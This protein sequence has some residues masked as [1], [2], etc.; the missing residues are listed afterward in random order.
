ML[1]V[2][3]VVETPSSQSIRARQVSS[4]FD[5][6][7]R[8]KTRLEWHVE[9]DLDAPWNVGLVVGPSGSGKSSIMRRI[10]GEPAQNDWSAASVLDDF[11]ANLSVEQ[12]SG[13]CQ[14]VGF[15]TI[16]A[17]LR[18][19]AVLSNGEKFRVDLARR[20]LEQDDPV[21]VDE[22]TSVVDR[23]VAQIGSNAVQKWVRRN[24]RQFV[25][26]TCHYDVIEWLQPDWVLD[27]ATCQFQRRRLQ[28]R[29]AVDVVVGRVP[30]AAWALFSPFHYLT[31]ELP[32]Q[33]TCFG[34]WASGRLAAFL[35]VRTVPVSCGAER[36][37]AIRMVSRVVTLPDWQGLGLAMI[38]QDAIAAQ[39][40]GA[41]YRFRCPPA[42]PS[43]VR[44]FDRSPNWRLVKKPGSFDTRL[45]GSTEA[46]RRRGVGRG[47]SKQRPCAIFEYCGPSAAPTLLPLSQ[48]RRAA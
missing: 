1:A 11:G 26:V 40:R 2:D 10:W 47:M 12:I 6:P 5:A 13:V 19:F 38:L 44:T 18:P 29:P 34:A 33:C 16:P 28:R 3:L 27:M 9:L 43:F 42:H 37:T 20:M 23:Q 15:N 7:V 4:M 25:A 48:L 41:G 14:A 30:A 46:I 36:G 32:R 22:F 24:K 35:G 21:V 17:W 8:D 39:Y 31:A 45:T